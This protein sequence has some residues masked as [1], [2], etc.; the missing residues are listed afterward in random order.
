MT[1][2]FP[3]ADKLVASLD[4]AVALGDDRAVESGRAPGETVVNDP[5]AELADG[6]T[7][8]EAPQGNRGPRARPR[9]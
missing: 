8:A 4:A 1:L 7:G 6:K 5:P 3:G 2:D 9:R